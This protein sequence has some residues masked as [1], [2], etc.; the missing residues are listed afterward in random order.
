MRCE[1][2][3]GSRCG[4][5]DGVIASTARDSRALSFEGGRTVRRGIK[6]QG[7]V[8]RRAKNGYEVF[9]RTNEIVNINYLFKL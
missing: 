1:R 6:K 7:L 8:Y 2:A 4:K 3:E 9:T 5:P